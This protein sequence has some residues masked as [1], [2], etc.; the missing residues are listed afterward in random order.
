MVHSLAWHPHGK[1]LAVACR[2][3]PGR[4]R[5]WN[6]E[7]GKEHAAL[8]GHKSQV[9]YCTFNPTG[10]LLATHG[11]DS[12]TRLW[13]P[14]GG[15]L[16]VS[17]PGWCRNFSQD[18]RHLA[19]LDDKSGEIG[20][21]EVA[22][23]R[24]CRTLHAFSEKGSGPWHVDIHPRGRLLASASEDGVRLWNLSTGQEM[25]RLNA[26]DS[27]TALFLTSGDLVTFGQAGLLRWRVAEEPAGDT[28]R[29]GA[30]KLLARMQTPTHY[31]NA[32]LSR[33]GR[34]LVAIGGPRQVMVL[35]PRANA[36]NLSHVV[37]ANEDFLEKV[38]V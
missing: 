13:D 8:V 34:K 27:R 17:F 36:S 7:T 24:E 16:L 10:D 22:A 9:M 14:A 30:A 2:E 1:L 32:R 33:D 20:Y 26:G 19:F 25:A 28:Y 35:N 21:W 31:S 23:G 6:T 37:G 3:S 5:L 12:T 38:Q 4:C 11:W 29:I 15:K 18:G